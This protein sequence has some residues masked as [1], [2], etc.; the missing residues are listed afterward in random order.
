MFQIVKS[1]RCKMVIFTLAD[2]FR[3]FWRPA[4][5]RRKQRARTPRSRRAELTRRAKRSTSPIRKLL[6][7][8][9]RRN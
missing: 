9:L 7:Q 8:E 5:P 6:T 2:R 1:N 4:I 3:F